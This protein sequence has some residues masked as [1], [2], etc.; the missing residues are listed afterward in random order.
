MK[1]NLVADYEIGGKHF[2]RTFSIHSSN[3]LVGLADMT[4]RAVPV[5]GGDWVRVEPKSLTMCA[6]AR[7]AF[8]TARYWEAEYKK[9]GRL[10]DWHFPVN[11]TATE[12]ESEVV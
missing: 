10:F 12:A 6:S 8:E 3:N 9:Q 11:A 1:L 4:A 7:K 5:S 2:C